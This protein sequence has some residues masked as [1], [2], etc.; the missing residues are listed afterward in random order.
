MSGSLFRTLA[1]KHASEF[2]LSL[3]LRYGEEKTL[4]SSEISAEGTLFLPP[5][6]PTLEREGVGGRVVVGV[7]GLGGRMCLLH[8][9]VHASC[10]ITAQAEAK[11]RT[12][13]T[14]M[15]CKNTELQACGN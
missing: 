2:S 14:A 12:D 8:E 9:K 3:N 7:G 15:S 10:D 13:Q 11:I 4:Y 5:R 6:Y 1:V